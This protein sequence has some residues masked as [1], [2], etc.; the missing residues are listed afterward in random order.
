ME[1][2]VLKSEKA[3]NTLNFEMRYS[4]KQKLLEPHYF[5]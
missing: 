1:K 2:N 4:Y 5:K 3:S